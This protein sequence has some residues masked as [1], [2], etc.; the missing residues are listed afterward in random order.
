MK[1][2]IILVLVTIASSALVNL[3]D[4]GAIP[5]SIADIKPGSLGL[6]RPESGI[7]E[8]KVTEAARTTHYATQIT[9][10]HPGRETADFPHFG[11]N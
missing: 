2:L 9:D 4:V 6:I 10:K 8:I 5:A 7:G 1:Y 11:N 3:H